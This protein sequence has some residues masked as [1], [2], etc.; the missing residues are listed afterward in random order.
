MNIDIN[1]IITLGN[2]EKYL[3]I[4]H[5]TNNNKDYYYIA[6]LDKNGKDIKDNYKIMLA[7]KLE[8]KVFLDEVVG[9]TNLK[10]VLPLFVKEITN[11]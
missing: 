9:E 6:E 1:K 10:T 11:N 4:S 3:V 8:E 2:Q 7:T 5:I